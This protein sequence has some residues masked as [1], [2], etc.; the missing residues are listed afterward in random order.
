[1]RARVPLASVSALLVATACVKLGP[2]TDLSRFF[3]LTPEPAAPA[4]ST[5]QGPIVGVG[6]VTLPEYLSRDVIVTRVGPNEVR[7]AA[8]DRWAEPLATQVPEIL[9]RN[10][11]ARM[12]A[13]RA[14]TYPWPRA[15]EP[16][17]TVRVDIVHFEADQA[18]T[19]RL[20]AFWSVMTGG[21]E[22]SGS[23][24]ATQ[25]VEGATVDAAVAALSALLRRLGDEI[26]AAVGR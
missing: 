9:A 8:A 25:A 7:L 1:M 21:T 11:D 20:D 22:R 14:V 24:A 19:A 6:P 2:S 18:G 26:A 12:G 23:T 4:A 17:V 3:L 13:S 16:D 10:L 5:A 15:M